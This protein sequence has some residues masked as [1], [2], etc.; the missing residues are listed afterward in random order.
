MAEGHG[1]KKPGNPPVY[2]WKGA[3]SGEAYAS[4]DEGERHT[5]TTRRR[6]ALTFFLKVEGVAVYA[7]HTIGDNE[8]EYATWT[9]PQR[10]VAGENPAPRPSPKMTSEPRAEI[11][12]L[13]AQRE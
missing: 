4:Q 7:I 10:A 8:D 12:G 13:S 9:R 11:V 2:R 1:P 5:R 3:N 6:S